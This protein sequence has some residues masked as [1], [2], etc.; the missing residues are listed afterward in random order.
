MKIKITLLLSLFMVQVVTYAQQNSI[1][2]RT[3]VSMPVGK[4][5]SA[6][7]DA[8]SGFASTGYYL[9]LGYAHKLNKYVAINGLIKYFNNGV[10]TKELQNQANISYQP[11]AAREP[12]VGNY[13]GIGALA[14][15][16]FNI[17]TSDRIETSII[18]NAGYMN[19]TNPNY[20]FD[21]YY[22]NLILLSETEKKSVGAF[23]YSFG[24]D[25]KYAVTNNLGILLNAA[26][27]GNRANLKDVKTTFSTGETNYFSAKAPMNTIDLGL[28]LAY[29]FK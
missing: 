20:R 2:F 16:T 28:G 19:L 15:L 7:N 9:D 3:G 10:D 22:N 5:A 4:F 6:A 21:Y 18:L 17:P 13:I 29:K 26:F 23:A 25:F 12:Q 27:L 24:A 11:Y 14:G 1:V 8:V